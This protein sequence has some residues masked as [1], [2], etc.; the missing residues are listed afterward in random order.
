MYMESHERRTGA[1]GAYCR[2]LSKSW[3]G[4]TLYDWLG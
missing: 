2:S 3:T 4:Q 1:W